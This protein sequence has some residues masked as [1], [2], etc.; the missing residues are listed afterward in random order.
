VEYTW[1]V[2]TWQSLQG[3]VACWQVAVTCP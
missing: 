2:M 1:N 3:N